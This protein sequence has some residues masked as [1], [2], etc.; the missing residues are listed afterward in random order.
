MPV[1]EVQPVENAVEPV[2]EE[3]A[4]EE[5]PPA[6]PAR[7]RR[8]KADAAAQEAATSSAD[9]L[10]AE[11]VSPGEVVDEEAGEADAARRGGWWQ[12]TFGT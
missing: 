7:A 12:R 5:A 9:T 6:K 4:A 3:A 8:K 1:S 2:A 11:P 10:V